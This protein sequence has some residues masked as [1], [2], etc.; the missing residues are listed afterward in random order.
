VANHRCALTQA[1]FGIPVI[2][3]GV[4]T[5]IGMHTIAEDLTG[6]PLKVPRPD[7]MVTPRD[8]DRL[9]AQAAHLLAC[10]INLALHPQMGY[11]DV[12]TLMA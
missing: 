9:I 6:H 7:M 12:C 4:P 10:G 5:V 1:Y 11:G 2:G 3:V 8:V